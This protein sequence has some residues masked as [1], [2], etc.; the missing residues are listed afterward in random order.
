M[1]V[2]LSNRLTFKDLQDGVALWG[3]QNFGDEEERPSYHPLLGVQEEVGELSHAHLKQEQGIRGT[4]EELEAKAKDAVGDIVI[5]LADYCTLRGFDM[6]EI[7]EET[8]QHVSKRNWKDNNN[9]MREM[10]QL[11]DDE[12][13]E[14]DEDD[15][16]LSTAARALSGG[17]VKDVEPFELPDDDWDP[18]DCKTAPPCWCGICKDEL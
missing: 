13:Y 1:E 12:L 6:Q 17:S 10:Y 11:D 8:W 18:H 14:L 5:F 16:S 9:E 2:L 15:N 3:R 7:V 4:P